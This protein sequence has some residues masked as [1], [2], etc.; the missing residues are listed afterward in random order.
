M[1]SK[2]DQKIVFEYAIYP[3]QSTY[4]VRLLLKAYYSK[5]R[6]CTEV[7]YTTFWILD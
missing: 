2:F 1:I 4:S 5:L 7:T 3:A 6:H